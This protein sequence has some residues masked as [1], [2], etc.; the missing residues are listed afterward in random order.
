MPAVHQPL[1]ANG[2]IRFIFLQNIL[3]AGL[4]S[5]RQCTV[6]VART[7]TSLAATNFLLLGNACQQLP[8]VYTNEHVQLQDVQ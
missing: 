7:S 1:V 2:D 4:Q 8:R 3:P 5:G 6:R